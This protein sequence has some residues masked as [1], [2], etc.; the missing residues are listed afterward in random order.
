MN[1]CMKMKSL[2]AYCCVAMIALASC[3]ALPMHAAGLQSQE[4]QTSRNQ[5]WQKAKNVAIDVAVF[6][7]CVA[8]SGALGWSV[9]KLWER[10]RHG[11]GERKLNNVWV[12]DCQTQVNLDAPLP[13]RSASLN[14]AHGVPSQQAGSQVGH[15]EAGMQHDEESASRPVSPEAPFIVEFERF[16]NARCAFEPEGDVEEIHCAD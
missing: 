14:T 8:A 10:Y 4:S 2:S 9:R 1:C 13:R 12:C 6:L 11:K 5:R 15:S 3:V 7:G 16:N